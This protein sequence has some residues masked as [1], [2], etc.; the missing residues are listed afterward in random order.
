MGFADQFRYHRKRRGWT[1]Q[2]AADRIGVSRSAVANY[3]SGR[4]IPHKEVLIRIANIFEVSIDELLRD[5][6]DVYYSRNE[7]ELD[8]AF[9]LIRN[10]LGEMKR[11]EAEK[12]ALEETKKLL[13]LLLDKNEITS[14]SHIHPLLAHVEALIRQLEKTK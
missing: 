8:K 7:I 9:E 3:E 11:G 13:L 12:Y 6:S 4:K 10:K 1:Q 2:E 5:E 14:A